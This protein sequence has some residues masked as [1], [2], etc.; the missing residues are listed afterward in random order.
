MGIETDF[1]VQ[2]HIKVPPWCFDSVGIH[3]RI[4]DVNANVWAGIEFVKAPNQKKSKMKPQFTK[5]NKNT[6]TL[7]CGGQPPPEINTT[8]F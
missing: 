1:G 7:F 4:Q 8:D 6:C 5:Y 2:A 3:L